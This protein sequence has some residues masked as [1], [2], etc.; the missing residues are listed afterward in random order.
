MHQAPPMHTPTLQGFVNIHSHAFQRALRGRVQSR[1]PQREDSFWTWREAMYRLANTL[2]LNDIEQIGRQCYMECLEAGYTTLGEFHYLHHAKDGRPW[3]DPGAASIALINAARQTGLRLNLLW[4]VYHCGGFDR[5]LQAQ[6]ARFSS[7]SLEEV[8]RAIDALL[9]RQ[10]SGF[11]MGLALHSV[12][13]VPE[14]WLGPLAQGARDRGLVIHAHVSEQP[15][16]NSAC[17]AATGLSP[18]ALLHKHGVL[19]PDFTAIHGTWLSPEDVGLLAGSGSLVGICPSTEGDLGDGVPDTAALLAAGVPLAIGSDSHALI[20]P[21]AELRM[22]EYQARARTQTRC[23]L[24]DESGSVAPRLA[25]IG[26][27]NGLKAL[28][29]EVNEDRVELD[30]Y[31]PALR[32]TP[33]P[34]EAALLAGH[35]GLV[36]R[37]VAQGQEVVVEGRHVAR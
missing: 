33:N 12:R 10:K 1:D 9:P 20:D 31:S 3:A 28:G 29:F 18:V 15:L 16:E 17:Q 30:P 6:Q 19:G 36:K 32:G 13:A 35:P 8:W 14:H 4:T 34:A 5:P 21:F 2:D 25:Q 7:R 24:T 22:L 11:N 26:C 27:V 23:V 37:V